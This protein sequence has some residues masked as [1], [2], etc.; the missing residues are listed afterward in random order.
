MHVTVVIPN[1]N[2]SLYLRERI[3]SVLSQTYQDFDIVIMDDCSTD[4]SRQIIE[5]YRSNPKV[6][7]IIYNEHNT[8]SPFVQW[9]RGIKYAKGEYVWIAESDDTCSPLFLEKLITC[10][11]ERENLSFA[12]VLSQCIFKD[13]SLG[14]VFQREFGESICFNGPMFFQKYLVNRNVIMNASAVLFK[15][16]FALSIDKTYTSY[17]GIGDWMF[18]VLLA[19]LG[20]VSVVAEVLNFY[21]KHDTNT[22]EKISRSGGEDIELY[23]F[24]SYLRSASYISSYTW[25]RLKARIIGRIL[26]TNYDTLSHKAEVEKQWCIKWYWRWLVCVNNYFRL[27]GLRH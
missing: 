22:I 24:Y 17:R 10:F 16:E 11:K 23:K 26:R 25:Y 7:A 8:G 4:N 15:R 1:Y 18:W 13:G 6:S 14:G 19:Q 2:H 9:E 3:D 12:F 5:S 27:I 21:R 20:E